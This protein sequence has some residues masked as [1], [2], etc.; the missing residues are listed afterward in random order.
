[1]SEGLAVSEETASKVINTH[2]Y[3]LEVTVLCW[4]L[5]G[6]LNFSLVGLLMELPECPHNMAAA[7]L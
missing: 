1:M 5:S 7:F 2:H 6:G 3:W 4:L